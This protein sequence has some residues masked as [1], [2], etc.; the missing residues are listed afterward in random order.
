MKKTNPI[1]FYTLKQVAQHL[2]KELKTDSYNVKTLL[3]LA[4]TY[5]LKLHLYVY[6]WEFTCGYI[7]KI[8]N[9]DGMEQQEREN[10]NENISRW[11]DFFVEQAIRY[12]GLIELDI[13]TIRLLQDKKK[14]SAIYGK[15]FYFSNILGLDGVFLTESKNYLSSLIKHTIQK[16]ELHNGALDILEKID[17]EIEIKNLHLFFTE[18]S[19]G[20]KDSIIPKYSNPEIVDEGLVSYSPVVK[21]KDVLITYN[22]FERILNGEL[23]KILDK[24]S[25]NFAEIKLGNRGV[26]SEKLNAKIAAQTLADYLWR[27]DEEKKIRIKD[28]ALN[29]FVELYKTEHSN[30]L[31]EK[32]ES[33]QPWIKN[34][35]DKYP[36]STQAGRPKNGT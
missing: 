15:D 1:P 13:A 20:E 7:F 35:A 24:H 21:R 22:Q 3:A 34:I 36:H 18:Q 14:I 25:H 11:L 2:N 33:L 6:G 12:G 9:N 19:I 29:V 16:K 10:L 26:S 17:G 30:Q 5:D 28:M 8:K 32:A 31:P 23:S 4:L 27:K